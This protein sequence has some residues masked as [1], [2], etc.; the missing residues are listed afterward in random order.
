MA[1]YKRGNTWWIDLY[2]NGKRYRISTKTHDKRKAEEIHAKVL[3]KLGSPQTEI[4]PEP[5]KLTQLAESSITYQEFYEKHYLTWCYGRQEFYESKKYYL[6]IIPDWFKNLELNRIGTKEV[7]LLQ[8][9]FIQ[10]KKTTATCNRYIAIFQASMTKA[11]DWNM[12]SEQRLKNIRKVKLIKGE[13]KRLRY[14]TK[15]EID[16][17]LSNCDRQLYPIVFTAL[18]TGMRKSEILN[19]KWSQVDLK[20]GIILLDKTKNFERREIPMSDSLKALFKQLHSQR[21]LN[22]DYVFV[23]PDTDKRYTDLKRSF[24][25]ACRRAGIKDFHFHD[26]RHTFASQ[27]VMSGA[28]LKTVQ[29]L[30]GHKSLTMTLRYSHLSQAH[31]REALKA[32]EINLSHT[33]VT[34]KSQSQE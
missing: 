25:T 16:K 24:A 13:N 10:K 33:L 12:I 14:L 26:L 2:H 29:E 5:E 27:L 20:N 34:V 30:L 18:H 17:L 23:N 6:N 11:C 7:E 22:T 4:V 28:D 1:L 32:L 21:R 9:Y 15:E 8:S 3:L 19:L 31:K